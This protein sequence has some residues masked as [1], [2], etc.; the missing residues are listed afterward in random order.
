MW[1]IACDVSV[2]THAGPAQDLGGGAR[3]L[4]PPAAA[5]VRVSGE[6]APL[7]AA[8]AAKRDLSPQLLAAVAWQESH[9]RSDAVSLK[10]AQ[11]VMQL[12]PATARALGVD[13]RDPRQ[14]I[15]GGAAYLAQ[16]LQ[17]FDGDLVKALA[18]YN[19]G[20]GAVERFGG[21]PPYA[22]TTRYVQ[23]VLTTLA[24]DARP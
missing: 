24:A 13:A 14:N 23:G 5:Q 7:I 1:G 19:A 21:P 16:L 11:G 2:V 4:T 9:G 15:D 20:S 3:P 10:G 18:A 22:E 8:A 6:V 17:R 12:M